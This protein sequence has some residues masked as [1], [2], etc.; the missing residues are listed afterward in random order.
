MISRKSL[1]DKESDKSLEQ[2]VLKIEQMRH[3]KTLI[4]KMFQHEHEC[5][6][7]CL[8]NMDDLDVERQAKIANLFR[9]ITGRNFV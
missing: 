6:L 8:A 9:R 4:A 5:Y 2:T 3:S 7:E 1:R